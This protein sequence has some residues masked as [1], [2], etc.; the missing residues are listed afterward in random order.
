MPG[1]K[2][3][4]DI[5]TNTTVCKVTVPTGLF[6][7]TAPQSTT[8]TGTPTG[9]IGT[10]KLASGAGTLACPNSAQTTSPVTR[11]DE[12]GFSDASTIT[13]TMKLNAFGKVKVCFG[14]DQP[15]LSDANPKFAQPGTGNLL[16]CSQV[17]N[18]LPCVDFI[19]NGSVQFRIKGHDP[20]FRLVPP[21]G[22]RLLWPSAFPVGKVGS[23]YAARLQSSGGKAPYH[24]K[25]AS[26]KLAGGLSLNG[27]TGAI[28]GKPTAK[29]VFSCL[30][31]ATDSESPPKSAEIVVSITIK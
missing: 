20:V 3:A 27:S 10:L 26:G 5:C 18:V 2:T 17:A 28:T 14:D 1:G 13:V 24:W 22:G 7:N 15:F 12:T 11:L 23:A 16:L 8:A 21:P 9:E 29:G 4:E 6:P 30:V 19:K 31:Q 25:I